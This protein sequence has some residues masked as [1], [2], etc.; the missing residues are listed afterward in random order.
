MGQAG[1]TTMAEQG[2]TEHLQQLLGGRARRCGPLIPE[3]L[4]GDI[5][6]VPV[7]RLSGIHGFS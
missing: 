5:P 7:V 1:V 3:R 4:R 2:L 6:V